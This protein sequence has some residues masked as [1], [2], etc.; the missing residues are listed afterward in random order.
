MR[1]CDYQR[2]RETH[3]EGG[4]EVEYLVHNLSGRAGELK[5][6]TR[7]TMTRRLHELS[8]CMKHQEPAFMEDSVKKTL[9]QLERAQQFIAMQNAVTDRKQLKPNH[10]PVVHRPETPIV[11]FATIGGLPTPPDSTRPSLESAGSTPPPS[12][13]EQA[14]TFWGVPAHNTSPRQPKVKPEPLRTPPK[15]GHQRTPVSSPPPAPAPR[16]RTTGPFTP[17]NVRTL[18]NNLPSV[19][20]QDPT[21]TSYLHRIQQLEAENARLREDLTQANRR[22]ETERDIAKAA[23]RAAGQWKAHYE[24]YKGEVWAFFRQSQR[25]EDLEPQDEDDGHESEE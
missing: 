3:P 18:L 23:R 9:E 25:V 10:T 1:S 6:E 16:R 14:R 12:T 13:A 21:P 15:T 7:Q 5:P 17:A 8:D 20:T 11:G 19:P 2:Y 22:A 24:R 4:K